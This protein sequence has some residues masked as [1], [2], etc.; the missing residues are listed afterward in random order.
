M[1]YAG[2]TEWLCDVFFVGKIVE[3]MTLV[4]LQNISLHAGVFPV[5]KMPYSPAKVCH[6][7]KI[8]IAT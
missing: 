2:W 4:L 6:G 3:I 8:I 7:V 1:D 5:I